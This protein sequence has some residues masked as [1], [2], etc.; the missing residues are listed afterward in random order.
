MTETKEKEEK[1]VQSPFD[2]G[3]SEPAS[4]KELDARKEMFI[5]QAKYD[6]L[7][8]DMNHPKGNDGKAIEAYIKSK[9]EELETAKKKWNRSINIHANLRS[10]RM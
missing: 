8:F 7:F 2:R 4:K 1:K 9:R 3:K 10:R 5:D 6:K